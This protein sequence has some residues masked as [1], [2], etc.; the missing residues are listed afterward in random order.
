MSQYFVGDQ[1]FT[2]EPA[3]GQLVLALLSDD[4]DPKL[5]SLAVYAGDGIYSDIKNNFLPIRMPV[6]GYYTVSEG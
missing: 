6:K 2:S 1:Y 5:W 4:P 3:L